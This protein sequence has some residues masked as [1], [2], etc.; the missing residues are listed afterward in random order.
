[1]KRLSKI[2]VVAFALLTLLMA[3]GPREASAHPMGNFSINQYSALTVGNDKVELRYIIDMAEIPTF[4][5]LSKIREDHSTDLTAQQRD[6]FISGKTAELSKGLSL[7][8]N[9]GPA[10]LTLRDTTL[11]FPA[12]SGGLPTL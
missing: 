7:T 2:G 6:A 10:P 1:M 9:G 4:Q 12:G 11:T 8:V 3:I 5:E